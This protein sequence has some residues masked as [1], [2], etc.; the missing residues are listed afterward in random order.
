MLLRCTMIAA[1]GT[2]VAA[3]GSSS[4]SPTEQ[5]DAGTPDPTPVAL[6]Y[7][8]TVRGNLEPCG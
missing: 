1:L 4:T 5:P 7:T 2:T 3:C 8:G 6:L